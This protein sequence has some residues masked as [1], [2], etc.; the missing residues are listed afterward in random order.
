MLFAGFFCPAFPLGL[1]PQVF[2][3]TSDGEEITESSFD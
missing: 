1:L 2:R 3:S